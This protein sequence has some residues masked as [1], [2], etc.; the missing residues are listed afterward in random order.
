MSGS[1]APQREHHCDLSNSQA[2]K[3]G[4]CLRKIPP[5]PDQLRQLDSFRQSFSPSYRDV[6]YRLTHIL[7][8]PVT[9][10]P[11]KST[12]SIVEKL[13]REKVRLSQM[14]D[15]AGCRVIVDDT[16]NQNNLLKKVCLILGSDSIDDR[17]SHPS[18]G[19]RAI[20]VIATLNGRPVEVQI[21]SRLQHIWAELSEKFADVFGSAIKY[22]QGDEDILHIL[23]DLSDRVA[24]V[25]QHEQIVA[26]VLQM[27]ADGRLKRLRNMGKATKEQIRAVK[28]ANAQLTAER[29]AAH[30]VLHEIRGLVSRHGLAS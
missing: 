18:H 28:N 24:T 8:M 16:I 7:G 17:R 21:R 3:L 9:G 10:R 12:A 19:Y 6:Y 20:H 14:Q 1:V 11:A 30:E 23:S 4:D 22:G 2:D 29:E 25:E 15:I 5:T 26:D 13:R 27:R